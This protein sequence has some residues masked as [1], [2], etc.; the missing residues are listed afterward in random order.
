MLKLKR[1]YLKSRLPFLLD[2]EEE[3]GGEEEDDEGRKET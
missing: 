2:T 1:M 3:E